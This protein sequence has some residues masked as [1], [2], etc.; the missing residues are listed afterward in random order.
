[1][2]PNK[3]NN[4]LS[5][6]ASLILH[7][8]ILSFF[9]ILI[10]TKASIPPKTETIPISLSV[11]EIIIKKPKQKTKIEK[12]NTTPAISK[13]PTRLPGDRKKALVTENSMP[14]Y[15]KN[16]INYG[17]EGSVT[18][19]VTINTNGQIAKIKLLKSSDHDLLDNAFI[20][21]VKSNYR[22]KPKRVMGINKIDTIILSH[23]FKL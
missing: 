19:K 18:I 6:L 3:K 20:Q 5:F 13:K 11:N 12:I 15:P 17:Y 1:M 14:I 21:H 8:L 10:P 16:A 2:N 9:T 23:K 22:F 7:L 4:I